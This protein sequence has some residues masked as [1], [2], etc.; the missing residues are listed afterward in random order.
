MN[1]A[2]AHEKLPALARLGGSIV[3]HKSNHSL[4]LG[5][6]NDPDSQQRQPLVRPMDLLP[7]HQRGIFQPF[8]TLPETLIS[9]QSHFTHDQT[10]QI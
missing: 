9:A 5:E 6:M 1:L 8:H 7:L 3:S 4:S 2:Q 10:D